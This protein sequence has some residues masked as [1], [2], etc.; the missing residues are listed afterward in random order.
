MDG[1]GQKRTDG[2]GPGYLLL[3]QAQADVKRIVRYLA[4]D[5]ASPGAARRFLDE[6]EKELH[7]I[8]SYPEMRPLGRMP[9]LARRGYRVGHVMRYV[10]LYAVKDGKAVVFHVFHGT[11]DYARYV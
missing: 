6:F 1:P 3:P 7:F 8:A 4:V 5:L 11:Q 10:V 2:A 9:E